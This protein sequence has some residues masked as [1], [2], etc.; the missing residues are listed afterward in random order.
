MFQ[1][2]CKPVS[3]SA[4]ATFLECPHANTT[5][6]ETEKHAVTVTKSRYF[7]AHYRTSPAENFC[8]F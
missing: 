8:C 5:C 3:G 7:V 1:D 2:G 6:T 4:I